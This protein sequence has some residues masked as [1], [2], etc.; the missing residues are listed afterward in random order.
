M[1]PSP[2]VAIVTGGGR[3]LGQ[4]IAIELAK[5][6]YNISISYNKSRIASLVTAKT[7][8]KLGKSVIIT[9]TDVTQKNQVKRLITRTIKRFGRIDLLINNAGIFKKGTILT[10]SESLWDATININLKG[11]FLCSQLVAPYMIKQKGGKIINIAS[12]GGVESWTNYLPYSVSKAGVIM[13]T[14]ILA[15]SLAPYI[16]VNAIAPGIIDFNDRSKTIDKRL[17]DKIL[18]K[19]WGKPSDITDLI[20]YLSEAENY[21]TGQVFIVDGGKSV[22]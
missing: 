13:L 1:K 20:V 9:K 22:I 18:L 7:I 15:K 2:K 10:T 5:H 11:L 16:H 21:I 4:A 19:R 3:R 8:E 14:R 17:K 6:G 12:I